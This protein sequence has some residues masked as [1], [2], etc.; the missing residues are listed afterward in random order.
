MTSLR[1]DRRFCGPPDSGNGGYVCGLFARAFGGSDCEVTL[2]HPPPLDRA[3]RIE[4]DQLLD[5]DTLIASAAAATVEVDIP[6]PPSLAQAA[7][8]QAR[9]TG[10][11][12]HSFPTCFVC[13][14]DRAEGDGL[15]IFAG[16]ANGEVAATWTPDPSLFDEDGALHSEFVWSALD[17]PGY[18]AIEEQA[19]LALLGRLAVK[20][21]E[22]H[23]G[24]EQLIV[25][26]WPISSEGR[27]H[28]AGTALHDVRGGLLAIG[29][30]TWVRLQGAQA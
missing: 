15:R 7:Q 27:K 2:H 10:F 20:I 19:G 11:S 29:R 22:R 13:G 28:V 14:P 16:A 24:H 6:P 3:L 1:I 12:G 18:F 8:A 25:T 9:F 5:G 23:I 17:C 30:A 4:G 21:L 26:G